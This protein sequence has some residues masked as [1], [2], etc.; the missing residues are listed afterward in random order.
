MFRTAA[1]ALWHSSFFMGSS[2]GVELEY[3]RDIP[4]ACKGS[5]QT[6]SE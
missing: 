1:A 6:V 2:A 3:G 5:Y 4:R